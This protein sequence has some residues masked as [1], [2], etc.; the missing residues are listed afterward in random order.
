MCVS[1]R[2]LGLEKPIKLETKNGNFSYKA[3]RELDSGKV[4]ALAYT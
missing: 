2:D 1:Y 3:A 4:E